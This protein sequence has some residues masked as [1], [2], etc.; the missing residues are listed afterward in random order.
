M[1]TCKQNSDKISWAQEIPHATSRAHFSEPFFERNRRKELRVFLGTF[2]RRRA[3]RSHYVVLQRQSVGKIPL[4][5]LPIS[6]LFEARLRPV[7]RDE[8]ETAAR[9]TSL[10]F[11]S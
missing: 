9:L 11:L 1:V 2:P 5:L 4:S 3:I 7:T 6:E 8:S 10:Q